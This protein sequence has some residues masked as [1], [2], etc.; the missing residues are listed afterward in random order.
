MLRKPGNLSMRTL[1]A[2]VRE[3]YTYGNTDGDNSR[4]N[5]AAIKIEGHGERGMPVHHRAQ[6]TLIQKL[7][8]PDL[9]V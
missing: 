6:K 3:E 5:T 9:P 8:M 1:Q 4:E 7:H 2:E